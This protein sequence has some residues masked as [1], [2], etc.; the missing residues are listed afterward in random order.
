[1]K[2]FKK[3]KKKNIAIILIIIFILSFFFFS[4][5]IIF[6]PDSGEYYQMGEIISGNWD[7]NF[8]ST[9]RGFGFPLII[10]IINHI[11]G[12]TMLGL[13]VAAF[14]S[15]LL[16]IFFSLFLINKI[17]NDSLIK[18]GGII[19]TILFISFNTL[20]I[21][22]Y[23][24]FLTEF[25][26]TT[27]ATIIIYVSY[28]WMSSDYI[29]NKKNIYYTL[30]FSAFMI[31]TW[32]LKQPYILLAL[33]PMLLSAI[34]SLID[35][36]NIKKMLV[37]IITLLFSIFS[38]IFGI[39]LWDSFLNNHTT[40]SKERTNS[41][42]LSNGIISGLTRYRKIGSVESY[43]YNKI[44]EDYHLSKNEKNNI[45]N[46]A[47][48]K[49]KYKDYIIYGYLDDS[50][51]IIDKD[52]ILLSDYKSI[53]LKQSINHLIN[54]L[55]YSPLLVL[56]SYYSNYMGIIGFYRVASDDP[57]YYYP[58]K[59][60]AMACCGEN[61]TI[62]NAIYNNDSN[63]LW[64]IDS[65]YYNE[66]LKNNSQYDFNFHRINFVK[67][68]LFNMVNRV[69]NV[70]FT[71]SLLIM[72]LLFTYFSF[73]KIIFRFRRIKPNYYMIENIILILS[74][75]CFFH[76][77]AQSILGAVIDRYAFPVYPLS[78]ICL[79]ILFIY[80]KNIFVISKNIYLKKE[81]SLRVKKT[82]KVLVVIPA[83]NEEAN[84]RKVLLELKNDCP[85]YDVLVINDCS[86]DNTKNIV[87]ENGIKCITHPFNMRYAKAVQTGL[88][89]A[90]NNNYD[91]VIQFDADGQHIAS[92]AK[93][94]VNEMKKGSYDIIIGSRFL[95]QNSYHHNFFRKI[96][97]KLFS[98]IIKI[99]TKEKI[100]DPTSGFQCLNR[101][102]VEKYSKMGEYPDYPDAN[103]ILEMLLKGYK[104]KEIPVK[105]RNREFG[106]SM[107]V[108]IIKPIIYVIKMLYAIMIIVLRNIKIKGEK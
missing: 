99:V 23:H 30:L 74:G 16:L 18:K 33:V 36:F 87:E 82:K 89:F 31:I 71:I 85:Q 73:K 26:M 53:T 77:L 46:I 83:Y 10:S 105:M 88:K 3:Y 4:F 52:I 91:Y 80:L 68:G 78:I 61:I 48:G 50:Y 34:I 66:F 38:L 96:G 81:D 24:V 6:T 5:P 35:G 20:I 15:Y 27:L 7:V 58:T 45:I 49:S 102:V 19:L 29:N 21:G 9:A 11:F 41:S 8:W 92:E 72:P 25:I 70:L 57:T 13:S 60:L 42:F 59:S 69:Y 28:K 14:L 62:G 43:D 12:R 40:I 103:L 97:T 1:M 44:V 65:F 22:Y 51:N 95:D 32:F 54:S 94:L 90:Y 104:I 101:K 17:K 79:I 67:T 64:K 56:D 84:I 76:I 107:H 75:T 106:E 47:T 2:I 39:I 37:K 98:A 93:K 55:K 108:G 100:S 63:V 86:K